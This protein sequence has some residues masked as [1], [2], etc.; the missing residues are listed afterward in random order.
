ML[1]I[2]GRRQTFQKTA[3]GRSEIIPRQVGKICSPAIASF[4]KRTMMS[5]DQGKK[6]S[7][8][9]FRPYSASLPESGHEW[10]SRC[11]IR[12]HEFQ[13]RIGKQNSCKQLPRRIPLLRSGICGRAQQYWRRQAKVMIIV[14]AAIFCIGYDEPLNE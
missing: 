6:K 11:G 13:K 9:V 14:T 8:Q 2:V 3:G 10:C 12:T 1:L 5:G 7:P 4:R